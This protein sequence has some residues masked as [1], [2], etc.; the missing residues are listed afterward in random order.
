MKTGS[1]LHQQDCW[2][3]YKSEKEGEGFEDQGKTEVTSTKK[4]RTEIGYGLKKKRNRILFNFLYF[5]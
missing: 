1:L 5:Q 2:E 3:P 4:Y